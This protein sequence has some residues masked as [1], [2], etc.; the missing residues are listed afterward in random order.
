MSYLLV[1]FWFTRIAAN[2]SSLS[3]FL[4]NRCGDSFLTIG[5]F[6]ILWCMGNLDYSTVFSLAPY[7]NV[8]VVTIIGICLLIGAMAKSAQLGLHVWLPQAIFNCRKWSVKSIIF[9]GYCILDHS[10]KLEG[11]NLPI[12]LDHIRF[13]VKPKDLKLLRWKRLKTIRSPDRRYLNI[14]LQTGSPRGG[15][16]AA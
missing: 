2:T 15:W 8:D 5:M 3:A 4:T 7:I 12:Y 14:S 1:S 13:R 10:F 6:G 11:L 16:N 9:R